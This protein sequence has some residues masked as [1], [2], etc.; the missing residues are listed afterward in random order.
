MAIF[1]NLNDVVYVFPMDLPAAEV[2]FIEK[3]QRSGNIAMTAGGTADKVLYRLAMRS[4]TKE[5]GELLGVKGAEH[6]HAAGQALSFLKQP[7][8]ID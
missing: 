3:C 7:G 8:K 5:N 1:N 2:K 4:R 6:V